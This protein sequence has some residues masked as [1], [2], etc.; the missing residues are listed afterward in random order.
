M[1]PELY[2]KRA[3]EKD[4]IVPCVFENLEYASQENCFGISKRLPIIGKGRGPGG[5]GSPPRLR[6]SRIAVIV[7]KN[8]RMARTSTTDVGYQWVILFRVD[9]RQ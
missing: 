2:Q 8:N 1:L 9:S 3:F 6:W 5:Y 4:N 7:T